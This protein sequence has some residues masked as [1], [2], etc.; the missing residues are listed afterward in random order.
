MMVLTTVLRLSLEGLTEKACLSMFIKI[1]F[2]GSSELLETMCIELPAVNK[3]TLRI[4]IP[5]CFP[6]LLTAII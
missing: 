3:V 1:L 5:T 6:F 2:A 4:F